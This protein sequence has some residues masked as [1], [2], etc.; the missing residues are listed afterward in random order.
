MADQMV[1]PPLGSPFDKN[2]TAAVIA[3]PPAAVPFDP[4]LHRDTIDD[5]NSAFRA[6]GLDFKGAYAGATTYAIG[7]YVLFSRGLYRKATAAVAGTAPV[8]GGNAAW[9]EVVPGSTAGPY[10]VS[11]LG[12]LIAEVLGRVVALYGGTIATATARLGTA[13]TSGPVTVTVSRDGVLVLTF[14]F[15][16]A[17]TTPTL[18]WAAGSSFTLAVDQVLQFEITAPGTGAANLA[19]AIGV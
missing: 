18:A 16:Q 9:T 13:S 19:L 4:A 5:L 7:E 15:A 12:T 1:R 11:V 8:A 14:S 10:H 17:S 6:V 2:V 3:S